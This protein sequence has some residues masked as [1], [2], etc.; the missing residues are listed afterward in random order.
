[1]P[2][3]VK[4]PFRTDVALRG[5]D[6]PVLIF[7]GREDDIIPVSH[8]RALAGMLPRAVYVETSGDHMNYPPD[9]GAF[10]GQIDRFVGMER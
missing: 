10:W 5:Y 3:I 1:V 7:H 8:G 2:W 4:H 9:L 6:K